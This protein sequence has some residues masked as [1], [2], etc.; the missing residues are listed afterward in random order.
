V[1]VMGWTR[2]TVDAEGSGMVEAYGGGGVCGVPGGWGSRE[3]VNEFE[4]AGACDL[5]TD[6]ARRKNDD[7]GW[8]GAWVGGVVDG[9]RMNVLICVAV[10]LLG[11]LARDD[12]DGPGEGGRTAVMGVGGYEC[13]LAVLSSLWCVNWTGSRGGGGG[14][15]RDLKDRDASTW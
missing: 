4:W 6:N 14:E 3:S 5:S 13:M 7:V 9:E 12:D 10:F 2:G 8:A 11:F 15:V 1:V